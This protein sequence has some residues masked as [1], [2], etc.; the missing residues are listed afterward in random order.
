MANYNNNNDSTVYWIGGGLLIAL[1]VVAFSLWGPLN[2]T[3]PQDLMPAAG[4]PA[5]IEETS[6]ETPALERA[7]PIDTESS[8]PL[9]MPAE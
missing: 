2:T 8:A 6:T 1:A 4:S 7:T 3:A 5:Y 9:P